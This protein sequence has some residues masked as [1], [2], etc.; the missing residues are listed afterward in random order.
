M[1]RRKYQF[2]EAKVRKYIAEGR[3]SGDGA[4]YKPWLTVYDLPSRG[5]SHRPFG[6]KTGRT[7]H[8]LS[9]GEWKSFIRFEYDAT[10]LDI[11]EQ[12]PLDRHQTMRVARDLGYKHPITTDGTPYVLTIDF[13]LTRYLEGKLLLEPLSFKYSPSNLSER[14]WELHNIA[15]ECVQ[16]NGLALRMIDERSF[17]ENF[18]RN[19]DSIRS[20]YDLTGR[21]GYDRQ[22]IARL[23]QPLIAAA[24]AAF[25]V[26][27]KEVCYEIGSRF[28]AEAGDVLAIA[29][30]L[31][32]RDVLTLNLSAYTDYTMAPMN[33]IRVRSKGGI[34]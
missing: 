9:D 21:H 23:A 16:R 8:L 30:H 1:S 25:P 32:A 12:F 27:L 18:I 19:Y 26:S 2:T 6:I 3:G 24:H 5:R 14:D 20:C 33:E 7:H 28:A 22:F 4:S 29:K 34:R 17:D 10:V 11:R 15:A 13:L 31:I